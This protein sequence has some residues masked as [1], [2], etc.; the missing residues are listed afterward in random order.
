MM[1]IA[2]VVSTRLA[3]LHLFTYDLYS[4]WEMTYVI[5]RWDNGIVAS[6]PEIRSSNYGDL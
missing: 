6:F 1:L 3:G 2:I 5:L 4:F